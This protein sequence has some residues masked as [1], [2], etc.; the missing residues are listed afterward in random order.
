MSAQPHPIDDGLYDRVAGAIY[1]V[2]EERGNSNRPQW[3]D[4][5]TERKVP[6]LKDAERV[7]KVCLTAGIVKQSLTVG[8]LAPAFR[9]LIDGEISMGRMREIVNLWLVG[10]PWR[11][12]SDVGER[13]LGDESP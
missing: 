10:M 7:V 3:N 12:P 13:K 4:L 2:E 6:W 5:S 9:C 1:D 8:D 11:L